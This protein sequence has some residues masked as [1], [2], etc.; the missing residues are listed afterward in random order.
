M[1]VEREGRW[2]QRR[3]EGIECNSHKFC[4][5]REEWE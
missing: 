1:R 3:P 2:E 5:M 4:E